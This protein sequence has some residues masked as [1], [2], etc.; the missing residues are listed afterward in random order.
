M[1]FCKI[2]VKILKPIWFECH[3]VILNNLNNNLLQ[4]YIKEMYSM[5]PATCCCCERD[6]DDLITCLNFNSDNSKS[7]TPIHN[8]LYLT[9]LLENS[10]G[11]VSL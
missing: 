3:S 8:I 10:L 4:N 7:T 5:L 11:N 1:E 9:S 6:K 2:I